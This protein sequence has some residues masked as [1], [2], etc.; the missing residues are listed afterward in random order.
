MT[1]GPVGQSAEEREQ[2]NLWNGFLTTLQ[3]V[4][5][6][7]QLLE[8]DNKNMLG[9]MDRVQQQFSEIVRQSG[10]FSFQQHEQNIFC[11]NQRLRCDGSTF[12]R[13]MQFLKLLGARKIGGI[14]F[15]G[16][17]TAGQWNQF[18]LAVSRYARESPTPYED[19]CRQIEQRGLNGIVELTPIESAMTMKRAKAVRLERRMFAVRTFAKCMALLR[20]YIRHLDNAAHRG[21][22]HLK[23]GRVLQD[24][25]TVCLENGWKYFGLT[26]T[27]HFDEYLYNH[28]VNVAVVSLALGVKAGLS[29][30]HLQELGMAALL[31]DL[32]KA[33]LPP[34]L[35]K[36]SGQFSE[37]ERK[38]LLQ[39]PAL[40][41]RALLRVKQYNE[42]L[43]K[44]IM[45]ICEHHEAVK[46]GNQHFYSRVI[47]VAETFD[48]LTSDRPHRKAF[49]PDA[50]VKMM[51]DM[52]GKRLD[53]D[54]VAL[55]V[56][57]LG[58]FPCGTCVRLN[59]GELAIVFHPAMD[60]KTWMLPIVRIIRDEKGLPYRSPRQ[61]DLSEPPKSGE[62]R[63]IE[64]TVDPVPLGINVS[65]YLYTEPSSGEGTMVR[66][67]A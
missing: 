11:N 2:H 45:V 23:L 41:V 12:M 6:L 33:F 53:R 51:I 7:G 62:P 67:K 39:H 31:H 63:W 28:S 43:L 37:A 5:N 15:K 27:K 10:S 8:P 14:Q 48:A 60:P 57:S 47:A 18:L 35:L 3:Q 58:L 17:M 66:A 24:L 42:A 22:F 30:S 56:Q 59:T 19:C 46:G 40:G 26:N 55:F 49:L 38:Q 25:V 21:Y 61:V 52:G 1:T 16:A 50:A 20:E 13:H 65:G 44:R 36:K 64:Q 54:I 4:I 9:P 34:E 29:R 32:G